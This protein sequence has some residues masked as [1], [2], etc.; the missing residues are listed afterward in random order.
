MKST[1]QIAS[2]FLGLC[3]AV[4]A[5]GASCGDR[6]TLE[7]VEER[8]GY[9]TCNFNNT[10]HFPT[11]ILNHNYIV[12]D[13][14]AWMGKVGGGIDPGR[15]GGYTGGTLGFTQMG[16]AKW[17]WRNETVHPG[18]SDVVQGMGAL[19]TIRTWDQSGSPGYGV[20]GGCQEYLQSDAP[21][22]NWSGTQW[23]SP[24]PFRL[25]QYGTNWLREVYNVVPPNGP[26]FQGTDGTMYYGP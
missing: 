7:E 19:Y 22:W 9:L 20:A 4:C 15:W 24:G 2:V 11:L 1:T 6:T 26:D 13:Y 17:V 18:G 8:Q 16:G 12:T 10:A 25:F 23:Y 5:V 21:L 14:T 3:L